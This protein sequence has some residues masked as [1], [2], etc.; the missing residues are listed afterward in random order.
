MTALIDLSTALPHCAPTVHVATMRRLVEIES[1]L[2]P[3]AI[4][5]VGARL[6]RQP[7]DYAEALATIRWLDANGYNYSV[8]LSQVNKH[9]F[10]AYGLTAETALL[11]CPNLAAGGAILTACYRRAADRIMSPQL[12]LRAALS[13]YESGN[14]ITGFRDGYVQRM[15][16]PLT[17][18][19]IARGIKPTPNFDAVARGVGI[20]ERP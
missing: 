4:G 11:A 6:L 8:G 7:S 5:V 17:S 15:V 16:A 20:S 10:K 1:A 12:A 19:P 13:C 2:N 18:I 9:N 14:F 3:F